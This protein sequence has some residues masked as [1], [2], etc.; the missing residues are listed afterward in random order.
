MHM[1][2]CSARIGTVHVQGW[3]VEELVIVS[4][5]EQAFSKFEAVTNL[6]WLTFAHSMRAHCYMSTCTCTYMYVH[7]IWNSLPLAQLNNNDVVPSKD[8]TVGPT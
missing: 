5:T 6:S 3:P 2:W 4:G 8:N 7:V 1:E